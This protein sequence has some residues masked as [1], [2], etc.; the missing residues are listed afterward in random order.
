MF[1]DNDI[2]GCYLLHL[3]RS[4]RGVYRMIDHPACLG[5]TITLEKINL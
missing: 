4:S 5:Y 3:F 1:H 2:T